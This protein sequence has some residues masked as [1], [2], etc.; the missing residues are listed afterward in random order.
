MAK[1]QKYLLQFQNPETEEMI[2]E[3]FETH[4]NRQSKVLEQ[5][6]TASLRKYNV[7]LADLKNLS[8]FKYNG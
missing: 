5:L 8:I 4:S 1:K 6:N 3:L 7:S 2:G